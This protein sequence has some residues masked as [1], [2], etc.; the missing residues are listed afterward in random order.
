MK[1]YSKLHDFFTTYINT[2]ED[3]KE[4]YNIW[5]HDKFGHTESSIIIDIIY[6]YIHMRM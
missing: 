5:L 3:I 1:K 4:L 2:H 6:N